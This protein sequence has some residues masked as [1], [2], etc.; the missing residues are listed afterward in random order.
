MVLKQLH[1]CRMINTC[2]DLQHTSNKATW[3]ATAKESQNVAKMS[4]SAPGNEM[5]SYLFEII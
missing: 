5:N 4:I 2:I 3:R 1:Y